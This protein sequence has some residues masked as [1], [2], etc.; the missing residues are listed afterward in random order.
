MRSNENQFKNEFDEWIKS[1]TEEEIQKQEDINSQ[2]PAIQ[3]HN[4]TFPGK[5]PYKLWKSKVRAVL[6]AEQQ[7]KFKWK[8]L[9]RLYWKY[10]GGFWKVYWF[11]YFKRKL[12]KR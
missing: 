3:Y 6:C 1:L 11:I 10:I 5:N 7:V 12:W 9:D 2:I 8:W 4:I